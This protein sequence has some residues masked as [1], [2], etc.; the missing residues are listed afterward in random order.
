MS[1]LTFIDFIKDFESLPHDWAKLLERMWCPRIQLKTSTDIPLKQRWR[2]GD[3]LLPTLFSIAQDSMMRRLSEPSKRWVAIAFVDDVAFFQDFKI[4]R[5][6]H[7]QHCNNMNKIH[8]SNFH[9]QKLN[10]FLTKTMS[11]PMYNYFSSAIYVKKDYSKT[12]M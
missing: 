9:F 11:K 7:C 5:L 2:Q 6:Q 10:F 12:K 1:I 8:D 3:N 4:T